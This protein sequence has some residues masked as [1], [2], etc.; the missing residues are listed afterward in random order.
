MEYKNETKNC[1][2]CKTDFTIEPEDFSFYEKIKVSPPVFCRDCRMVRKYLWRNER[3][4]Y[5]RNCSKTNKSIV[6]M[7]SSDSPFVIYDL[8]EWWGDDWNAM[9]Y[10][11]DFDFSRS[12]FEQFRELQLRV[13]R[14][15]LLNKNCVNSDF[16]NHS[17]DSK[18]AY[19][20]VTL[21]KS[22]NIM[23]S[24]NAFPLKNSSDVYRSEGSS[25]ENLFECINV[26]DCYN[27]QYCYMIYSS[28]DCYYSF[29]LKN[30]SN[31]FLSYNLRGQSYVFMNQ[32]FSKEEYFEKI[33]EFNLKSNF[34]RQK[35]YKQWM[36][37][38]FSKAMHRG[39]FVEGS[40][41]STGSFVFKSNNT[42]ESFDV[43][44]M[45]NCK[46]IDLSLGM[47]D[48]YDCYHVGI[49]CEITYENHAVVRSSGGRFVHLSY[50][51]TNI[52]YCDSCHNSNELFGCVG[53]KKGA[54]M[55]L[56]KQ[57]SKDAYLEL[58][59]KIIEHMKTTGEWGQFF[60]PELSPFA[61]NETQAQIYFPLE[62][63][64][65]INQGYRWKDD[66]PG[67]FGKETIQIKDIPD[68][69]DDVDESIIGQV[70]A[71][72]RSGRNYNLT[73]Q[74]YDFFKNHK[75]PIP[76]LHPNERYLDRINIRPARKL[77]DTVCAISGEKIKTAYPPE[78]R[79][80]IIVSDE[81]Y[82]KEV[83]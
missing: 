54:Y 5:R 52:T 1:Q 60:P 33:K 51:N 15:A 4:L 22:E 72:E 31:C 38:I 29:D 80:K 7:Y 24:A 45:D 75:I 32:K 69:I 27:C 30:C 10:A 81:V 73:R 67:T 25:N 65:A 26:R 77:F 79:P 23:H 13:P 68:S 40:V 39:M 8:K 64:E 18:D 74:E 46:N 11:Q 14:L 48:S 70:L 78:R 56:N 36:E 50:D 76:R 57:Y 6:S 37:I 35:L 62:R 42:K 3:S 55:I 41:H 2:N 12:F 21:F 58:K 82:K 61:Y 44:N 19:M 20:S 28:F 47:K 83:L 34:E 59:E 49:N 71:C 63:T 43:E 9:D 16:S 66:L 17:T 53:V